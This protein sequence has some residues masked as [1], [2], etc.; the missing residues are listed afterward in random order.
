MTSVTF[1]AHLAGVSCLRNVHLWSQGVPSH[2]DPE[3]RA[4]RAVSDIS[5]DVKTA[6]KPDRKHYTDVQSAARFP[7]KT[8]RSDLRWIS[9]S[10]YQPMW[11]VLPKMF[12]WIAG[13]G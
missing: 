1:A 9:R 3:S 11:W 8:C 10:H 4:A 6:N 7:V 13:D 5:K 12:E 2:C